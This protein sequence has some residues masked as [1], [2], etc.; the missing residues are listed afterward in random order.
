MISCTF[1]TSNDLESFQVLLLVATLQL[2][3]PK[4]AFQ[5]EIVTFLLCI[6]GT[7]QHQEPYNSSTL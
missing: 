1:S 4:E 2:G 5:I 6:S 3:F 7:R